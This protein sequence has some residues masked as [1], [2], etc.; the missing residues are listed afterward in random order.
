MRRRISY[1]LAAALAGAMLV[2]ATADTARSGLPVG[3]PLGPPFQLPRPKAGKAIFVPVTVTGTLAVGVTNPK[4]TLVEIG[5]PPAALRAVYKR[6][7]PTTVDGV[8]K[9]RFLVA[10]GD[11]R[12]PIRRFAA[13]AWPG[14]ASLYINTYLFGEPEE[15]DAP[16]EVEVSPP[17][18]CGALFRAWTNK[19]IAEMK[20]LIGGGSET[21]EEMY[22]LA[23]KRANCQ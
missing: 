14:A 15:W 10:I 17:I 16:P 20:I 21:P 13:A 3:Q 6:K 23:M 9:V 5:R 7:R 19:E 12:K 1:L 4:L 8:T 22:T 2:P 18:A 11:T